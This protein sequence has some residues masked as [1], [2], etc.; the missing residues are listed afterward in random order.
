MTG[1]CPRICRIG[2]AIDDIGIVAVDHDALQPIGRS[3]V[4]CRMLDRCDFSDRRVL[5]IEIVLAHEYDGQLPYDGKIERFMESADIG[6]AVAE[7]ANRN[8]A[9]TFV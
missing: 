7:E 5:H 2:G 3:A 9:L 1:P 8:V 4:G 6:G